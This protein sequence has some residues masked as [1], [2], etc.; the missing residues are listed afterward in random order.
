MNSIIETMKTL[1]WGVEV[2][3]TGDTR[4]N[5][6]Y[7]I[8]EIVGG[9]VEHEPYP[10][11]YDAYKVV[12]DRNRTWKIMSDASLE[13]APFNLRAELVTPILKY[14]NILELQEII[15]NIRK[16]TKAR[17]SKS[18]SMHYVEK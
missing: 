5:V 7:A 10:R 9:R 8:K 16:S 15:R 1:N 13:D 3:M 11:C 6:A 18:C 12:D 2:E 17:M 4:K 14:D